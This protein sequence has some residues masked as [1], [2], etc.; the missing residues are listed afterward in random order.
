MKKILFVFIFLL[1][2]QSLFPQSEIMKF[3]SMGFNARNNSN[4]GTFYFFMDMKGILR[5]SFLILL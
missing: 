4:S 1:V 5:H 2:Y 3:L